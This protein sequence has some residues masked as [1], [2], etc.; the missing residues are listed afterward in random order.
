MI[1]DEAHKAA[2]RIA[3]MYVSDML[4]A[5]RTPLWFSVPTSKPL[6]RRERFMRRISDYRERVALAWRVLKGED[7]HEDC[8]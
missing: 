1:N 5:I 4:R 2:Q 3:N 6:T 7:I 8:Y